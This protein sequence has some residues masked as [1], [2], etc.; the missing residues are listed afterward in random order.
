MNTFYYLDICT[1]CIRIDGQNFQESK[2][3]KTIFRIKYTPIRSLN[4]MH[5]FN[6]YDAIIT[7]FSIV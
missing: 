3:A 6:N 5:K 2:F 1:K 7:V 4:F